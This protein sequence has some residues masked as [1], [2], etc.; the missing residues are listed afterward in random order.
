MAE[1]LISAVVGDMVGRVISL[2]ASRCSNQEQSTDDKLQ[3]I[4]RMLIR[5]HSVVE[6]AKGRHITNDVALD[7]LSDLDDGVWQGR[8][9]STRSDAE[10]QS[11]KKMS[12]VMVRRYN[13][14]PCPCSILQSGCVSL[15]AP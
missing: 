8:I 13:L 4:S 15:R 3:K 1:V 10:I 11:M 5:I 14:S 2:L 9:C 6:E 7:W 12:M